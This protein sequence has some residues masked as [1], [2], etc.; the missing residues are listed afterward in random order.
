[1]SK[2]IQLNTNGGNF[3]ERYLRHSKINRWKITLISKNFCKFFLKFL[4][5]VCIKMETYANESAFDMMKIQQG[6]RV[7]CLVRTMNAE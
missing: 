5:V 7:N 2:K 1:M 3:T 4:T 6:A